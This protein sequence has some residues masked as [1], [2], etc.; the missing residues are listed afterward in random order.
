MIQQTKH[1]YQFGPFRIDAAER[2]L[3]R[4]GEVIPLTPKAFDLLLTLVTHS[5]HMLEKEELMKQV[6]PDSFVEEANLSRIIFTLR[7]ALGEKHDGHQYI[8]TIPTRGYRFVV[9][10][11]ELGISN[12]ELRISNEE[13]R[14]S[15]EAPPPNSSFE[16]R[17][18]KF[19][20]SHSGPWYKRLTRPKQVTAIALPLC[21]VIAAIGTWRWMRP[22]AKVSIAVL[23]F[24][25]LSS[26]PE[27]EYFSDGLTEEIIQSLSGVEGLEVTSQTSSFALKGAHLDIREIGGK[28]NATVLLEGSVRKVGDRLKATAQLI[29]AADGKHLWS[30]SYDRQMRD[31]FAIQ[32][33]I[34]G[35]IANALRLKFGAGQR[36]YTDNLEAYQLYLQG[37][38]AL[39]H[40]SVANALHYFEHAIEKDTNYALAYAGAADAFLAMNRDHMLPH[41]EAHSQARAAAD[42]ALQLDPMLSEAHTALAMIRAREYAW[43]EAERIFRRAIGLNPSNALA[44]QELG[45]SVLIPL[46]RVDEGLA[47]IRRSLALDP[48]SW[49]TSQIL[50]WA[51]V[52][53]GR[54]AEA[55]DQA[56][57]AIV[58]DPTRPE[59][60]LFLGRALYWQG[61]NAEGLAAMQEGDRRAPGGQATGWLACACVRAGRRDEA[62]RLLQEDLRGAG[63]RPAPNSRLLTF[64]ACLGDKESAFEYLEKMYEERFPLLPHFLM[65]AELAWMR[66]DPRFAAL[67]Q[68][69][70]LPP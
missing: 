38:Y 3:L 62:L 56:R 47:E 35:S 31:I 6:W 40:R 57:K 4:E 23:P 42:K 27:N 68:K 19:P 10:V 48:L 63:G 49:W 12:D 64:Y 14:S 17:H 45:N 43:Q 33:E 34:A 65:Y 26:D 11:T 51:L 39:E 7:K 16:I 36:R 25:N 61:R 67:R 21:L 22:S 58:L 37:R 8:E 55:E 1:F 29:R 52:S 41:G 15:T 46:G 20:V 69:I 32:E 18:S 28:L 30:N 24:V 70:G 59:S 66:S 5:G 54:Y 44:H 53:T 2:L 60:Y 9:D 50:A 13:A